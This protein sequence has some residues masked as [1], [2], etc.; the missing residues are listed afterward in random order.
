MK[1]INI[2]ILN[3]LKG[4]DH[5]Y[6]IFIIVKYINFINLF[7]KKEDK[8]LLKEINIQSYFIKLKNSE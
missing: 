7:Q 3:N 8:V 1:N 5:Y 4:F 6:K 2:S